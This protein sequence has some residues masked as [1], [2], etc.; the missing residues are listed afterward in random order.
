MEM[1][2]EERERGA[3]VV[4]LRGRLDRDAANAIEPRLNDLSASRERL[5]IDFAGVNYI[6]WMGMRMFLLVGKA[7]AAQGGT[8]ALM[9]PPPTLPAS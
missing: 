9:A 2:V 3:T 4:V 6:A 8:I 7:L 1:S 5:I